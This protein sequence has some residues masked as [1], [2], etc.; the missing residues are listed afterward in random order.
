MRP[1]DLDEIVGQEQVI[2]FLKKVL[3][4]PPSL[5]LWG[6][7]GSGKTTIARVIAKKS[8]LKIETLSAVSDGLPALRKVIAKSE[9][10]PVLLF[11]DEIHRWNKAQQDALLPYVENGQ[12]ALI[13]ATTENP[14][15]EINPALRSRMQ[16][17]KLDPL[18]ESDIKSLINKAAQ[19]YNFKVDDQAMTDII[20]HANGDGRKALLAIDRALLINSERVSEEAVQKSIGERMPS[21]SR[22]GQRDAIVSAFI[23][24]MRISDV[25]GTLYWLA[26]MKE[27]G[28]DPSFIARRM[29]IFASEDIG[30]ADSL[31]VSVAV[32]AKEAVVFVGQPECWINLSHVAT[33]LALAPKSWQAYRSWLRAIDLVQRGEVF[34]PPPEVK[35]DKYIHP[36]DSEKALLS[37]LPAKLKGLIFKKK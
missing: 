3:P 37:F 5:L 7:P 8:G 30:L 11:I 13:G 1:K 26:R 36:A 31:A 4:N 23:K 10:E 9:E 18:S 34:N 24:S 17:L 15:Y 28:E 19:E 16:L 14:G 29:I 12:I 32:S 25:E 33:Y 22:V 2:D 35:K 6:P 21:Y 27:G 20:N